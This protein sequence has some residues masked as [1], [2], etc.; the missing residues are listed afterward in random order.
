[1]VCVP[2]VL[3]GFEIML[4]KAASLFMNLE[5]G[6]FVFIMIHVA[7]T[8]EN[9]SVPQPASATQGNIAVEGTIESDVHCTGK[10]C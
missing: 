10:H 1:M 6:V 7:N 8:K 9:R 5:V 2:C 3:Q 4:E